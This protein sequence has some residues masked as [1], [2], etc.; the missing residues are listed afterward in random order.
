MTRT[1]QDYFRPIELPGTERPLR[2]LS[3]GST[4]EPQP[5]P[6]SR[7]RPG[8]RPEGRGCGWAGLR[9]RRG[10]ERRA[11][12]RLL[13]SPPAAPAA[14]PG[15]RGGGAEAPRLLL[16]RRAGPLRSALGAVSLSLCPLG[17]LLLALTAADGGRG[18]GSRPSG[19][20][21]GAEEAHSG[22]RSREPGTERP[23]P[24]RTPI[25]SSTSSSATQVLVN[26]AYCYSLQTRGSSQCMTSQL[27]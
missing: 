25:S 15:R 12:P 16:F 8:T 9:G 26:R 10:S 19:A 23:R 18:P 7:R 20:G 17:S 21:E 5:A 1:Y 14:L 13:L 2:L 27:V 24:W 11:R 22:R 4:A 6:V 3:R